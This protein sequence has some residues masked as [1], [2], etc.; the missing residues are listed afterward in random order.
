MGSVAHL[1]QARITVGV[2]THKDAH[3]AAAKD[4]LGR[5]LG[6]T[7]I[8]TTPEGYQALLAWGRS[9]GE[10]EAWGVEGTGS[11][12]AALSRFLREAGQ[13]VIEVTRPDRA[14]RRHR[15]SPT[16]SMP[17]RLRGRCRRGRPWACPSP[18]MRPWR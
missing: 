9:H 18:A 7:T 1:E 16:P 13:V 6:T 15:G 12:G 10:V 11:Y 4:H 8:P 14:A 17:R 3:V 2:D 5:S